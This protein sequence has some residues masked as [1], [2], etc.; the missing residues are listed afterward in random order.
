MAID[1]TPLI[2]ER[3]ECSIQ[4][5]KKYN[6]DPIILLAVAATENGKPG[7]W[8]KNTNGTH[9]VGAMQLNTA[10]LATLSKYGITANDV[11]KPGCYSYYLA[12]WRIKKHIVYDKNGDIWTKVSNYH[13]YTPKYNSRYRQKLIANAQQWKAKLNDFPYYV[14]SNREN[15]NI[16]VT[17]TATQEPVNINF[18]QSDKAT[19]SVVWRSSTPIIQ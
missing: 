2:Q 6:F 4:A 16:T 5:A 10:Y 3:I 12:A 14:K 1:I 15:K 7:Q 8:V 19:S 17:T 11:A 18:T 9:D 13:S